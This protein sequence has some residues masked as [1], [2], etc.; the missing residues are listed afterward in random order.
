MMRT[1]L[2]GTAFAALLPGAAM[3]DPA[4]DLGAALLSTV[5]AGHRVAL[6]P[7]RGPDSVLDPATAR[8]LYE[9]VL[10]GLFAAAQARHTIL[11]RERLSQVYETCEEFFTCGDLATRLEAARADVEVQC[12][13]AP[14]A[15]AVALYCSAIHIETATTAGRGNAVFPRAG[16]APGLTWSDAATDTARQLDAAMSVPGDIARVTV[17]DQRSGRQTPL[18]QLIGSRL[19]ADLARRM[20]VRLAETEAEAAA[21]AQLGGDDTVPNTPRYTLR[22]VLWAAGPARMV[23][24]VEALHDE[25]VAAMAQADLDRAALPADLTETGGGAVDADTVR[26]EA[27]V[28]AALD[29]R[30]AFRAA[31]NLARAR[32]IAQAIGLPAPPLTRVATEAEAAVV[33]AEALAHGIP[34]GER[35]E[36]LATPLEQ[37][38]IAV[39]LTARVRALTGTGQLDAA[40]DRAIYAAGAPI[41]LTLDARTAL[42]IGVFAW[43]ADNAVVRLYPTPQAA[44]H[45]SAGEARTLP[46]ASERRRIASA[47][48][49]A[50]P[51]MPANREDH[52]LILVVAAPTP[53]DF[54][55]LA[56]LAGATLAETQTRAVAATEFLHAVATLP[57]QGL[58]LRALPFQVVDR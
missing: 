58:V 42:H 41:R 14:R 15:D 25:R 17:I 35:F 34:F 52:E 19:R 13:A 28:S 56:P 12:A 22:G 3:A 6:R 47:P 38:R 45:L 9:E 51:D 5:P 4:L 40:L 23:L 7:L 26:G 30:A 20:T 18:G 53:I 8:T 16:L 49:P 57:Q 39:D 44:L 50:G 31:R 54:A 48:L 46:Q 37:A 36:S 11:P 55:A 24:S 10:T 21:R 33:L 2:F 43:G 29:A 32:R 27:L 1:L